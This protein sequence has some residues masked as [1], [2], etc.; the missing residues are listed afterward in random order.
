MKTPFIVTMLAVATFSLDGLRLGAAEPSRLRYRLDVT[1]EIKRAFL[2]SDTI[3]IREISGT[4][5]KFQVGGTYRVVGTCRQEAVR[6][7][8]LYIGNTAEPGSVATAAVA[9][10]SLY[11]ACVN[12]STDFD[13]SF[14]LLRP[15]ILHVTIYDMD[16][17]DKKDNAYAGI[18]LGDVVLPH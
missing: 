10:S 14:T 17:S 15:G 6:T 5:P 9:G 4:A 13:V 18:Y 7:A 16:N 12:G 3:E 11:K 1:P 8:Q 2:G